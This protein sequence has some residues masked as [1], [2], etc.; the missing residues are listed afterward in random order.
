MILFLLMLFGL[1]T[2]L[3]ETLE[4]LISVPV[5]VPIPAG[6]ILTKLFMFLYFYPLLVG[7]WEVA[8][9]LSLS[10][11]ELVDREADESATKPTALLFFDTLLFFCGTER[12]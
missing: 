6:F 4:F 11:C 1:T 7:G 5:P 9:L 8:I 12:S 2:I 10:V 3:D